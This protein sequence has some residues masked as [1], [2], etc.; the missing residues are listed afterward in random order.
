MKATRLSKVGVVKK[1]EHALIR[2][3]NNNL[4]FWINTQASN[5]TIDPSGFEIRFLLRIEEVQSVRA[6]ARYHKISI[7]YNIC[8]HCLV[9]FVEEALL[10]G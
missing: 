4:S 10:H 6:A 8:H 3:D 7:T 2:A 9:G 1:E 5:S